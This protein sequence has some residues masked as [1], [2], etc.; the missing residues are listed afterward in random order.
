ML[1][2]SQVADLCVISDKRKTGDF[3]FHFFSYITMTPYGDHGDIT[4]PW[5]TSNANASFSFF[6]QKMHNFPHLLMLSPTV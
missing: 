4:L 5:T 1:K 3:A 6:F 2:K